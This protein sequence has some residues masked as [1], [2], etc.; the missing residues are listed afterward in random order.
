M[1]KGARGRAPGGNYKISATYM[2]GYKATAVANFG[3]GKAAKKARV[4]ADSILAR[5]R[6]VYK[7]MGIPDFEKTHVQILGSEE[8]LGG[9]AVAESLLP[10]E[11]VLWMSVKHQNKKALD[12]W[13]KEI[14]ACGT[15]G[16][17]GITAVVGGRPKASPC[18][19]LFSF[20]YPKQK[21][22]ATITIE[23]QTE[24]YSAKSVDPE[25]SPEPEGPLQENLLRGSTEAT[26]E[27]LA[28]T[29]SGDKGNSCNIGIIARDPAFLPY[30]REQLTEEVVAKYFAHVFEGEAIVKRY[31]VPGINGLN[32]VL[33]AALG[34]G[35]IASL[36]PDPQG[37][38]Y[39]QILGD[40]VLK[41][42]PDLDELRST[43]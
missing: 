3:G 24:T 31:E 20:L 5:T 8:S 12:I 32:F 15:G 21:L 26:L 29:R 7:K 13:A 14:A 41:N 17:P 9:S 4:M 28:Y 35:G 22:D 30:I 36:R 16:T 33:H 6:T 40:F 2:D 18:L 27:E 1:V 43:I 34:G 10:R 19:K 11:A 38:A 23:G 42:L 25:P 39:G 37:K